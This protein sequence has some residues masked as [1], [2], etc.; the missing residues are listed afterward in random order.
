M[1]LL[2]P[3]IQKLMAAQDVAGLRAA[4][5]YPDREVRR[6]AARALGWIELP[7]SATERHYLRYLWFG[8]RLGTSTRVKLPAMADGRRGIVPQE[9]V[10]DLEACWRGGELS[11]LLVEAAVEAM[12][13]IGG[14]AGVEAVIRSIAELGRHP[15]IWSFDKYDYFCKLGVEE[16]IG[17]LNDEARPLDLRATV[18]T[19]LKFG[20]RVLSWKFNTRFSTWTAEETARAGEAVTESDRRRD[21]RL[22]REK[23]E[24]GERASAAAAGEE[25]RQRFLASPEPSA[26]EAAQILA[27]IYDSSPYPGGGFVKVEAPARPAREIGEHLDESGGFPLMRDA[28]AQFSALRPAMARNLEMVWDGIGA[29]SG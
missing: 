26:Q 27:W 7:P 10:A 18:Y 3:N 15:G 14:P 1:R 20:P 9:A 21:E 25:R 5:R 17:I 22:A 13:R 24:K 16:L 12:A 2:G 23:K 29:W 8:N 4:L 28:H 6:D 11:K 19:A